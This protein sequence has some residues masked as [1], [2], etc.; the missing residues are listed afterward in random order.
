MARSDPARRSTLRAVCT[1]AFECPH[2]VTAAPARVAGLAAPLL[3][4]TCR[5]AAKLSRVGVCTILQLLPR[6]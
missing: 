4:P 6:R 2:P 1:Q 5:P 3:T